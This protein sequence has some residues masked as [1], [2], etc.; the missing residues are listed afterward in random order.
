MVAAQCQAGTVSNRVP[1]AAEMVLNIRYTETTDADV[2]LQ[3]LAAVSGLEVTCRVRCSPVC[4]SED[5]PVLKEL[6]E[7]MRRTLEHPISLKR[8]NG[9]TDARHFVSLGIPIGILGI[10]GKGPHASDEAIELAGL[11]AYEE[12]LVTF[13]APGV[14]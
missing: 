8:L 1:D 14:A 2:L 11:R 5:T 9:A 6:L 12:M 13:L 4:L 3:H 10:P 7:H